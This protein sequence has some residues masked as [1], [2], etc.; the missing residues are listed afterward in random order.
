MPVQVILHTIVGS[1]AGA[2]SVM[3]SDRTPGEAHL[4]APFSTGLVQLMPFDRRADCQW[5]AN[6]WVTPIDLG[7]ADGRVVRS[8]TVVG[9]ISIETEDDGTPEN[10]PWTANQLDRMAEFLAWANRELGIPLDRCPNPFLPGV[11]YHS[12]WGMNRLK[13][14]E[15]NAT[16]PY[17]TFVDSLGRTVNVYNPWTNT[18]G[19]SCPAEARIAQ[20]AG[21]IAAARALVAA[22]TSAGPRSVGP[23]T[24][25][26]GGAQ[27]ADRRRE[28]G[29]PCRPAPVGVGR[30]RLAAAA[31][32][33]GGL[34]AAAR[35]RAGRAR[36]LR[37]RPLDAGVAVLDAD[38]RAALYGQS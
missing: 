33:R 24:T 14:W 19:K 11:G 36:P 30:R 12:M 13:V 8:G 4:V 22:T 32:E 5:K 7:P 23:D 34:P 25:H 3:H 18:V 38:V 16:P 1:A 10:T 28:Q 35:L 15:P 27:D 17:G 20:F 6:A 31:R 9:A 29:Q 26:H 2:I 21:V 37:Y